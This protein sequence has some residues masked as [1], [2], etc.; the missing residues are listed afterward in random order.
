MPVRWAWLRRWSWLGLP[1]LSAAF[2]AKFWHQHWTDL[3]W[4]VRDLDETQW[5]A[6][7]TSW[8]LWLDAALL[9]MGGLSAGMLVRFGRRPWRF[10]VAA[11]LLVLATVQ[12]TFPLPVALDAGRWGWLPLGLLAT[13]VMAGLLERPA[14]THRL[15]LMGY[16]ALLLGAFVWQVGGPHLSQLD[17]LNRPWG[18]MTQPAYWLAV[19]GPTLRNIGWGVLL[20]C[21]GLIWLERSPAF[22]RSTL[23]RVLVYST[24]TVGIALTFT[25][26]VGLLGHLLPQG[27]QLWLLV[28]AATLV[29]VGMEPARRTLTHSTRQLLFGEGDDPA[30]VLQ[31][32]SGLLSLQAQTGLQTALDEVRQ[33]M[34]LRGLRLQLLNGEVIQSGS[35]TSEGESFSLVA[36]GERLGQLNVAYRSPGEP[37]SEG[38]R[39]LL[40][41]VA[42]QLAGSARAWQ[43][44]AD[45]ARAQ[46][47][48]VRAGEEERLRLRRDLHD[49]LGP[50]LSAL[51]L[52]IEAAR[53]LMS[54]SPERAQEQLL[55]LKTEVQDSVSEVRRIVH[56]LRPPKLDD[57][58][59]TGALKDLAGSVEEAG[60]HISCDL[61]PLD[62][63]LDAATQVALY[64]IAQEA[65]TNVLKHA[66][67]SHV[68]LK[69]F[70]QEGEVVLECLDNGVGLPEV[71]EAGVG[72]RS[73]RER[74]GAL[75][76]SLELRDAAG[77]GTVL[78]AR[79][80][81]RS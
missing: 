21:S 75:S 19:L 76:G 34:R 48:L 8:R 49:G 56:D 55:Q 72:S 35:E 28:L 31:R 10:G 43:L 16:L 23:T 52:K 63:L 80:P 11:L 59:F 47:K 24:L 36:Q 38:E 81:L 42:W 54:H 66:G 58:G 51:G 74:A 29:A 22:L 20:L 70:K 41:A 78:R 79:I 57:L 73:M 6:T 65:L 4:S 14:V 2:V 15:L 69:V 17:D 64:R 27:N 12:S 33:A 53:L 61:M 1:L 46:D 26:I 39:E 3:V 50:A 30:R 71:R 32:L 67:A 62:D 68:S 40:R 13:L 25:V 37:F 9:V 5:P 60:L 77:G 18:I 7:F 45:L 44:R